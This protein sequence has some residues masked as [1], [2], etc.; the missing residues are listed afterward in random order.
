MVQTVKLPKQKYPIVQII[1]EDIYSPDSGWIKP[2]SVSEHAKPCLISS[3]GYL[4][5]CDEMYLM[6]ASDIAD[7]GTANGVTQ[8]PKSNV[9]V[10]K[11]LRKVPS[12][13]N[14]EKKTSL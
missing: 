11:I 3:V 4:I 6:Y 2:E 1:W 8:V 7:D 12:V 14:K 5:P 9:K 13:K 10:L